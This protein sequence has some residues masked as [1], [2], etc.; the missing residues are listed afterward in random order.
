MFERFQPGRCHYILIFGYVCLQ[1]FVSKDVARH[2]GFESAE[3]AVRGFYNRV[4]KG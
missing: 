3:A 2:F 4:K 1:V